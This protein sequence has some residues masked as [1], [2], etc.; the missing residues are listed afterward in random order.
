M[1]VEQGLSPTDAATARA[2]QLGVRQKEIGRPTIEAPPT[3][4]YADALRGLI[5]IPQALTQSEPRSYTTPGKLTHTLSPVLGMA[6]IGASAGPVG[7]LGGAAL[8]AF[9]KAMS[10]GSPRMQKALEN[11]A[12]VDMFLGHPSVGMVSTGGK[13]LDKAAHEA[14]SISYYTDRL[15]KIAQGVKGKY[16]TFNLDDLADAGMER[17]QTILGRPEVMDFATPRE[18]G[19]YLDKSAYDS[20]QDYA[21]KELKHTSPTTHSEISTLPEGAVSGLEDA[22]QSSKADSL[23]NDATTGELGDSIDRMM[24]GFL[25]PRDRTI[26]ERTTTATTQH[27]GPHQLPSSSRGLAKDLNSHERTIRKAKAQAQQTISAQAPRLKSLMK[28]GKLNLNEAIDELVGEYAPNYSNMNK[29]YRKDIGT[30]YERANVDAALESLPDNLQPLVRD[31]MRGLE[32]SKLA[33]KYGAEATSPYN[34][35]EG[36]KLLEEKLRAKPN[37]M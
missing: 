9:A 10:Y 33:R 36:L 4:R 7:A 6:A 17:V 5:N 3:D 25:R 11:W 34:L 14:L 30:L 18:L 12:D 37:G 27:A 23:A 16:Q 20:M 13:V 29:A 32:P 31:Y 8:G 19:Q 24:L 22:R 1:F 28:G 26:F 2:Q 21:A 35:N 15:K